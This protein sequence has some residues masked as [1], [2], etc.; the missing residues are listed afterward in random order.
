MKIIFLINIFNQPDNAIFTTYYRHSINS[1]RR[2]D[3]IKFFDMKI[4]VYF[5]I[6]LLKFNRNYSRLP[7]AA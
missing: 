5:D 6:V 4:Y 2:F 7:Y 1:I 3:R